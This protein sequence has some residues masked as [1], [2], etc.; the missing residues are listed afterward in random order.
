MRHVKAGAEGMESAAL[1]RSVDAQL[2]QILGRVGTPVLEVRKEASLDNSKK[3]ADL[4]IE[5]GLRGVRWNLVV[6]VVS[7]GEPRFVREK[8]WWL[9]R[10]LQNAPER[11]YGIVAA[12]FLSEESREILQEGG[13]GWLDMA[14]NCRLV[15][16]GVHIDIE[17]TAQNPFASKRSLRSLFA[18]KSARLLRILLTNPRVWKVQELATRAQVSLGQV[19]KVRQALLEKEWAVAESAGGLR[20]HRPNAVLDAWRDVVQRPEIALRGYTLFHGKELEA[21]LRQLFGQAHADHVGIQLASY[22]V[23]RRLAPFVRIAGEFFYSDSVGTEIIKKQLRVEVVTKGENVIIYAPRDE[24]M[25]DE[26]IV[27]PN[28]LSG[29]GL[30]QTYLDL[31]ASG[32]RGREAAEHFRREA[33]GPIMKVQA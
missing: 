2:R 30:V 28:D 17:K 1:I 31:W 6:E 21:R 7:S 3:R 5:L 12:P 15:F 13:F 10:A 19:S 9:Q 29:A 16:D 18:P 33:M 24:R 14:G 27:L 4:L 26:G 20:V 32:D 23:A 8:S 22:A 25:F 11:S